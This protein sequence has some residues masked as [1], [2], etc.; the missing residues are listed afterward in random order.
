[1]DTGIIPG[2]IV[3][4]SLGDC[5]FLAAVCAISEVGARIRRLFLSRAVNAQKIY[6]ISYC[7]TGVWEEIIMD[8]YFAVDPMLGYQPAFS[9]TKDNQ[10]WVM[11]LIKAWAKLYG[12]YLNINSGTSMEVLADLTGA[13]VGH[14]ELR[15]ESEEAQWAKISAASS[16]KFIMCSDSKKLPNAGNDGVDPLTGI[17]AFHAY[18]VIGTYEVMKD[19]KEWRLVKESEK[20]RSS[21]ER[22]V[23]LRNPWGIGEYKGE[24]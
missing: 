16:K 24:W 17:I 10:L 2:N 7:V 11:L 15:D 6:C 14:F 5:Y 18:S 20:G 21:N 1:M 13:P 3:Q 22:L 4:R 12:G 9:C 8:D 19:G 23:K